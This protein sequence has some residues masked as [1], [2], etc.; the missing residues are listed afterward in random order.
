MF[1]QLFMLLN[2]RLFHIAFNSVNGM[3]FVVI[4]ISYILYSYLS[5][6]N[7]YNSTYITLSIIYLRIRQ[8]IH[9]DYVDRYM[10]LKVKHYILL[11]FEK[12]HKSE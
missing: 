7:S 9:C 8:K 2:E 4:Y 3:I 10:N 12:H 11:M 1:S 6:N 5:M